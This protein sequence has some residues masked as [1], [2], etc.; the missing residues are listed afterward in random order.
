MYLRAV[1]VA[2]VH[3]C[4][5]RSRLRGCDFTCG[6]P[7][8]WQTFATR[9]GRRCPRRVR[10]GVQHRGTGAG[11]GGVN[12]VQEHP[13]AVSHSPGRRDIESGGHATASHP[14]NCC[15]WATVQV[16]HGRRW[17]WSLKSSAA[18]VGESRAIVFPCI[19]E[20][21][22]NCLIWACV[23]VQ[24]E[25]EA[26]TRPA[27]KLSL[28]PSFPAAGRSDPE[29][30]GVCS[31][32][33]QSVD[34]ASGVPTREAETASSHPTRPSHPKPPPPPAAD[35]TKLC[36]VHQQ[37]AMG[38]LEWQKIPSSLSELCINTTLRCGQSFR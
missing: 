32:H 28:A 34:S 37:R 31:H 18:D 23:H 13:R 33:D 24:K 16:R 35:P 27:V 26:Q 29:P 5:H 12:M 25:D 38:A 22:P 3:V 20:F 36:R 4:S 14:R 30:P 15:Q 17:K 8:R 2:E 11:A 21:P 19:A 10:R 6:R 9:L 7:K 1:S